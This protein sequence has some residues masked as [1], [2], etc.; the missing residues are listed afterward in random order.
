ML[1]SSATGLVGSSAGATAQATQRQAHGGRRGLPV[2]FELSPLQRRLPSQQTIAL[3][4]SNHGTDIDID[5]NISVDIDMDV[6]IHATVN[7]E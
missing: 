7:I 4:L 3:F 2:L 6:D 1:R 5:A